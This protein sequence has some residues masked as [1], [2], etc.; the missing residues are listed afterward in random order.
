M[1]STSKPKNP[2]NQQSTIQEAYLTTR[3][4]IQRTKRI[5]QQDEQ[6]QQVLN[7]LE[8]R[9]TKD[10]FS[11]HIESLQKLFAAREQGFV[12]CLYKKTI[13]YES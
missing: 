7:L 2:I 6:F 12:S 9:H 8:D 4:S 5:S 10:Q 11:R 13:F 1:E 3:S